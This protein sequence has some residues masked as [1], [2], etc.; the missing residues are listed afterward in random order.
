MS[1]TLL[2]SN[3]LS[4]WAGGC[5]FWAVL[6]GPIDLA[7]LVHVWRSEIWSGWGRRTSWDRGDEGAVTGEG[8]G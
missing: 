3:L 7:G 2:G 5:L 8:A 1:V 6:I 4:D